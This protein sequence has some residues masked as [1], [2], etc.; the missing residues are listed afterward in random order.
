MANNNDKNVLVD[1]FSNLRYRFKRIALK[2]LNGEEDAEDA[3]QDAFCKLWTHCDKIKSASEAEALITVAVRNASIDSWRKQQHYQSV[4][5]NQE[6]KSET[7]DSTYNSIETKEKYHLIEM[8]I[9][10]KLTSLQQEIL[11]RRDF[12]GEEYE[13]IA[14]SLNMQQSAVRVQLSRA[15]KTI[16]EIYQKMEK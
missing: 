10:Q 9:E 3:L 4:E 8:I 13:Q 7:T 6:I 15:R 5:L 14:E 16:R 2:I 12:E 11:K 1:T